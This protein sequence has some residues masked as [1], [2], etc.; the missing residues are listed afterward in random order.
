MSQKAIYYLNNG[1]KSLVAAAV[2][3]PENER[4]KANTK[5]KCCFS[6]LYINKT[7]WDFFCRAYQDNILLTFH[8]SICQKVF[9]SLRGHNLKLLSKFKN[10]K[11]KNQR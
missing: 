9:A 7:V 6:L 8:R 2:Q 4:I 5:D 11:I 10:N 1:L 3:S